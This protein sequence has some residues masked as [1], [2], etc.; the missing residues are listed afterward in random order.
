MSIANPVYANAAFA[1]CIAAAAS[2]SAPG[3]VTDEDATILQA[4]SNCAQAVDAAIATAQGVG[5]D[6]TVSSAAGVTVV[7]ATAAEANALATKPAL[8][9]TLVQK[10][11]ANTYSTSGNWLSIGTTQTPSVASFGPLATQV[12]ASFVAA[13]GAAG[14]TTT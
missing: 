9:Q 1:G 5:H 11:L 13:V 12:A 8:L 10:A 14:W 4:A 3:V 7:P 6:P 2:A